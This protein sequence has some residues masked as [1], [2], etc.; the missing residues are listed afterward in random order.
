MSCHEFFHVGHAE[1]GNLLITDTNPRQ[2]FDFLSSGVDREK[3]IEEWE[4]WLRYRP[5]FVNRCT[6]LGGGAD[7]FG[8]Y[9]L[10]MKNNEDQMRQKEEH[11]CSFIY[12]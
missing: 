4:I 8:L 12:F 7:M 5:G 2:H 9:F 1:F 6:R 10:C 11:Q 3:R